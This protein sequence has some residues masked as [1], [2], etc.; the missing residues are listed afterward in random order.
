MNAVLLSN[1]VGNT[2]VI[3]G[4]E[5]KPKLEATTAGVLAELPARPAKRFWLY[6]KLARFAA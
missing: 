6:R 5:K 1:T 4:G 3:G 2:I